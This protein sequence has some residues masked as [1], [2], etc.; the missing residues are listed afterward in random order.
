MAEV[1]HMRGGGG[2]GGRGAWQE[3]EEGGGAGSLTC[4]SLR[5][6]RSLLSPG[7]AMGSE[8]RGHPCFT[9]PRGAP[10][11]PLGPG[12][13]RACGWRLIPGEGPAPCAPWQAEGAGR[14]VGVGRA[15]CQLGHDPARDS[16]GG[17]GSASR[18]DPIDVGLQDPLPREKAAWKAS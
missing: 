2:G 16:V 7:A 11:S 17:T 1:R 14:G 9:G 10:A 18:G 8:Y 4:P 15:V 6:R 5:G 3:A 13:R 12:K